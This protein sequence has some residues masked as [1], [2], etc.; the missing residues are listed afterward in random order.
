MSNSKHERIEDGLSDDYSKDSDN[1]LQSMFQV[2][3][4]MDH[5]S[6]T[7]IA[8]TTSNE[9]AFTQNV[10]KNST[11]GNMDTEQKSGFA[12]DPKDYD[13]EC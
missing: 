2:L 5:N 3:M 8:I 11:K 4:L 13:K 10:K 12:K 1:Y 7:P 6:K 9:T